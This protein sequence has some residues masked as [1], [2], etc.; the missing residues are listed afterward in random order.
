I[1]FATAAVGFAVVV[2]TLGVTTVL[3][4]TECNRQ[5]LPNPCFFT[6]PQDTGTPLASLKTAEPIPQDPQLAEGGPFIANKTALLQLG[7]ALFWDT[8]VGSDGQACAS[9]H[10]SAGADNRV[11]NAV[12]PGLKVQPTPDHTFQVPFAQGGP[13]GTVTQSDFPIHKLSDLN[14]R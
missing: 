11:K 10:F 2:A 8:Q 5:G 3:S 14:N 13:N 4:E 7:K 1:G 12:S 6:P 9:C